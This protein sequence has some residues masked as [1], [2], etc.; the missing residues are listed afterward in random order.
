MRAIAIEVSRLT[1]L[2]LAFHV[3]LKLANVTPIF[4]KDDAMKKENYRPINILPN[5]SKIY[6]KVLYNQIS[7]FFDNVFSKH[8]CGFRKGLSSQHCLVA[9]LGKC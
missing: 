9:M 3:N 7:S 8:Q 6:E 2:E 4:K 5:I 1:E